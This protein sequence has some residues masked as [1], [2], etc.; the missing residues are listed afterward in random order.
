MI[1][2]CF[3]IIITTLIFI[4]TD[5]FLN[6]FTDDPYILTIGFSILALGFLLEPGRCLNIVCGQS[7]QASGDAKYVMLVTTMVLWFFSVPLYY[8][9]GIYLGYGLIGIWIAFIIDEWIRGFLLYFR[10]KKRKWES[11]KL[12]SK[13]H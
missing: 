7:L 13:E 12:I 9:L 11:H 2:I 3:S 10:W 4:N 1:S 8:L 6:L 5:L